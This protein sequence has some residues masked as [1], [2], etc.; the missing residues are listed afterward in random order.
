[1]NKL[2][3]ENEEVTQIIII[4]QRCFFL[5]LVIC[6]KVHHN[7]IGEHFLFKSICKCFVYEKLEANTPGYSL[8]AIS[9]LLQV[10]Q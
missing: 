1:M 2:N 5:L 8:T 3:K 10:S 4:I 9:E 7:S 6:F